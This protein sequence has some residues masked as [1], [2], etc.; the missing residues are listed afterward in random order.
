MENVT[1][2]VE[3]EGNGVTVEVAGVDSYNEVLAYE[4]ALL[5]IRNFT[6][7]N[8]LLIRRNITAEPCPVTGKRLVVKHVV[9]I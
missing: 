9:G 8:G 3:R 5:L 4:N 2:Y 7:E 6:E 1:G